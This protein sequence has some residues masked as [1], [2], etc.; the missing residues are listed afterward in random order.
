MEIWRIG[1]ALTLLG[2]VVCLALF[3]ADAVDDWL[4]K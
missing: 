1:E 4:R 2:M 3:I